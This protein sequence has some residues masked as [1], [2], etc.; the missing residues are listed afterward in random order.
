MAESK[1][2]N[3]FESLTLESVSEDYVQKI[4]EHELLLMW[5]K[6]YVKR[7]KFKNLHISGAFI[8]LRNR[9]REF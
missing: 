6:A 3:F 7:K 8:R 2:S 4:S 1:N 9:L 5:L